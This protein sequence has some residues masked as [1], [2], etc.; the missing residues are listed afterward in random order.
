M[1]PGDRESIWIPCASFWCFLEKEH[2]VILLYYD[3]DTQRRLYEGRNISEGFYA[4]PGLNDWG[5][6][7]RQ[8][9]YCGLSSACVYFYY[10]TTLILY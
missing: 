3:K 8:G 10:P 7:K 2:F 9:A 5:Q 4:D 1:D 6:Y